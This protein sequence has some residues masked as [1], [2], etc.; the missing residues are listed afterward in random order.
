MVGIL[1]TLVVYLMLYVFPSMAKIS[2]L[3]RRTFR[4]EEK[5]AQLENR[6]DEFQPVTASEW[7]TLQAQEKT[8]PQ[9]LRPGF[10][11]E[12]ITEAGERLRRA[13]ETRIPHLEILR[14]VLL[15]VEEFSRKKSNNQIY[16]PSP[17]GTLQYFALQLTLRGD[18][19]EI[20]DFTRLF[21]QQIFYIL[22]DSLDYRPLVTH[23]DYRITVRLFYRSEKA[24]VGK[25]SLIP[26]EIDP[27]ALLHPVNPRFLH[28]P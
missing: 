9:S 23:A 16:F 26:F 24:D 25:E 28:H 10:H 22:S 3:R 8:T 5:Q 14:F 12:E 19:G 11:T 20:L 27:D 4:I 7:Q 15:P 21:P 13:I 2:Q 6:V 1:L 17:Y 18:R